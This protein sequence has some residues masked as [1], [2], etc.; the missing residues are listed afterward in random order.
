MDAPLARRER[1]DDVRDHDQ[2]ALALA[3]AGA[4]VLVFALLSALFTPRGPVTAQQA[5]VTM[6][7][8]LAVGLI[9]W[10]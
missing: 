2:S 3:I 8:A 10:P 1:Q 7:V 4:S 6:V 9:V 5:L